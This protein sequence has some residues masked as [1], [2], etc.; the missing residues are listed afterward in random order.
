LWAGD[1][2]VGE[3]AIVE[4]KTVRGLHAAVIGG[5]F[6]PQL[7][8]IRRI[9]RFAYLLIEGADLDDG[10]L[11][12]AAVRGVCVG[13]MDLRIAVIR[14]QDPLD[15][16]RWLYRLAVRRSRFT[17]RTRPAYAQ[18]PKSLQPTPGEALL[19]A[20]PGISSGAA[21]ALL[22]RFGNVAAVVNATPDTWQEVRGIGP[23]RSRAMALTF[24]AATTASGSRLGREPQGPAT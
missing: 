7:G 4:R 15:S 23:K 12:A 3:R 11:A 21:K 24:H 5:A 14:S 9:S 1:Y 18:R 6:W 19:A 10:P 2:E 17:Y 20:V 22:H 16:A 8:R 13:V